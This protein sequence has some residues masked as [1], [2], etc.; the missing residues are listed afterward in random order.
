M[1]RQV[2]TRGRQMPKR[3]R[4]ARVPR[5]AQTPLPW[6]LHQGRPPLPQ[7]PPGRRRPAGRLR[8][9]CCRRR[10]A[11]SRAAV[12]G[13]HVWAPA[14]GRVPPAWHRQAAGPR[15][16]RPQQAGSGPMRAPGASSWSSPSQRWA[17]AVWPPQR[18]PGVL[19]PGLP[20]ASV[21]RWAARWRV[22]AG[23]WRRRAGRVVCRLQPQS[24]P[25]EP[26]PGW[27]QQP[28]RSAPSGRPAA[29]PTTP[30]ADTTAG[31]SG[32]RKGHGDGHETWPPVYR[33]LRP[34]S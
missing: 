1:Q 17:R 25:W 5:L 31:G 9:Q 26:Q 11:P 34:A 21:P 22:C 32:Q 3:H 30:G 23:A 27:L 16:A 19:Q 15:P 33:P 13:N 28:R 12:A 8:A 14:D 6:P 4:P 20:H 7:P 24:Q 2:A 10:V 29:G 18:A